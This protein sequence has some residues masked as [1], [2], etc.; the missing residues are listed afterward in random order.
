MINKKMYWNLSNFHVIQLCKQ[1]GLEAER[2]LLRCLF[3]S[4]D[5]SDAHSKNSLQA[6]LLT[7]ELSSLLNKSTFV[8]NLCFAIEHPLPQQKVSGNFE[9]KEN[10]NLWNNQKL[11]SDHSPIAEL[12]PS[13]LKSSQLLANPRSFSRACFKEFIEL[14]ICEIR[15]AT[16]EDLLISTHTNLHWIRWVSFSDSQ[17]THQFINNLRF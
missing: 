14:R 13:A 1:F 11:I 9:W 3:S 6:K 7:S 5:F 4:I 12:Y 10:K 16:S 2:H 17:S 15:W 8:S